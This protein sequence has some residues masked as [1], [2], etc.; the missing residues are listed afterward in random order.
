[1]KPITVTISPL[2]RL[3]FGLLSLVTS[4]VVCIFVSLVCDLFFFSSDHISTH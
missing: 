2:C 3:V 4:L 1:M